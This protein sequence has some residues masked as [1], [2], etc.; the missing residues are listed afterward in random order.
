M[1]P[2][3]SMTKVMDTGRFTLSNPSSTRRV[4]ATGGL[5]RTFLGWVGSIPWA[6]SRGAPSAMLGSTGRK[7]KTGQGGALALRT[8]QEGAE[9]LRALALLGRHRRQVQD[10]VGVIGP[11]R[12]LVRVD[13]HHRERLVP[14]PRIDRA[15]HH[16]VLV[17]HGRGEIAGA[18]REHL[19]REE[20][21]R[22]P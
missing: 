10:R 4:T 14:I 9:G 18:A 22:A 19:V 7:P 8:E 12:A 16:E 11:E 2:E 6:A 5:G 1:D 13:G 15:L 3:V 17:E 21:G 20:A